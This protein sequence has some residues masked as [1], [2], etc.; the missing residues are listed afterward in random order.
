MKM[1][2]KEFRDWCNRRAC[3]GCWGIGEISICM[4]AI[5]EV[6]SASLSLEFRAF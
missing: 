6:E 2:Y 3:D 1:N 4:S 5:N